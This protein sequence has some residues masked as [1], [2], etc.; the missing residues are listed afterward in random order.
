MPNG[1][2][3]TTDSIPFKVGYY[4]PSTKIVVNQLSANLVPQPSTPVPELATL[5]L[6]GSGLVSLGLW[7]RRKFKA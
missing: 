2:S 6:L 7:G 5:L 4:D 1:G 3:P